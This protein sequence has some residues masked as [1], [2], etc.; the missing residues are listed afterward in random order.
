[1]GNISC[2]LRRIWQGP[3]LATGSPVPPRQEL[4]M[5]HASLLRKT[6]SG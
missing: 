1:M 3:L 6:S 4:G 5:E 2:H